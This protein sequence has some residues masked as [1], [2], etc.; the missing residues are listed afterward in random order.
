M[1]EQSGREEAVRLTLTRGYQTDVDSLSNL[2]TTRTAILPRVSKQ[3]SL[4]CGTCGALLQA[5]VAS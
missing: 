2:A 3:E 5:G 4:T 1:W